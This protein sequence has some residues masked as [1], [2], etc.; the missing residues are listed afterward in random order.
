MNALSP[1][2]KVSPEVVARMIVQMTEPA[3]GRTS[4]RH[5]VRQTMPSY[6]EARHHRLIMA[7]LQMVEAGVISRLIISMPPRH[8]KSELVSVRFPAWYLGRHPDQDVIHVSYGADL[9]ND[10][11]RR[12]RGLVRDDAVFHALFPTVVLDPER[13]RVND[14]RLS[15]GGG[16]RSVGTGAGITG[17]GA[18]LLIVDDPH[19]ETE[20]TPT[21]LRQ[22]FDWYITGARTRLMPGGRIVICMTRWDPADLVGQVIKA[23]NADPS[24]D[25]W[26]VLN[27]PALAGED[28]PLGRE[29]GEA[30]WSE[31]YPLESLQ[32]IRSLSES[33]FEALFQQ[34]PRALV[35]EMFAATDWRRGNM[36]TV[37]GPRPAWCF[38]LALGEDEAGDYTA[39][40]RVTY[41]RLSGQMGLAHLFRQRLTWPEAKNKIVELMKLYPE[42]DFVFPKHTFELMAVQT[43]RAEVPGMAG[44][45]QQVSFPAHSDKRSRAQ[46]TAERLKAGKIS[47]QEGELTDVW[48]RE[49]TD[50]PSEHD[51]CVDVV[52]VGTHHFGLQYEFSA[53]IADMGAEARRRATLLQRERATME[54]MGVLSVHAS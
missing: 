41:D 31:W 19:K 2:S 18:D 12:V 46:V 13:Q 7:A 9:S 40:A 53:A 8:G 28:D 35:M 48:I 33:Y 43:L 5:F 20:I 27:L 39:W 22:V 51:D 11:S 44:R 36:V 15:N 30:L 37:V 4:C 6:E 10:F 42:D 25:Q 16:F 49:H 26:Y 47:I 14:W 17:H 34:N 45:I 1:I 23:A 54:R 50:F 32:A 29:P 38:D 3:L 24:A 52:T 21:T